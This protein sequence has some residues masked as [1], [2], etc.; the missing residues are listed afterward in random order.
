M[1]PLVSIITPTYNH[2]DYIAE[3][4]DS[5]IHQSYSNWEMIIIDDGSS[6]NTLSIARLFEKKNNRIKVYT[7]ENIGIF[8]LAE[9]YN[10]ALGMAKGEYIAILEGHHH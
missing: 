6:D 4:I 2:Q 3:C 8:R 7:Q 10:K 1:P 9:T 5:V